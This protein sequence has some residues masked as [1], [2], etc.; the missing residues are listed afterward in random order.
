MIEEERKIAESSPEAADAVTRE[1][2]AETTTVKAAE[3]TAGNTADI[4]SGNTIGNAAGIPSGNTIKNAAGNTVE[5]IADKPKSRKRDILETVLYLAVV[6]GII[7]VFSLIGLINGLI[8]AIL[9]V[10]PFIATLGMQTVVYGFCLV[11]TG[12]Q[13]I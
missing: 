1:Q 10:P 3:K 8:I 12:A 7:L 4:L 9:N 11:F 6:V 13:P 5:D 2:T